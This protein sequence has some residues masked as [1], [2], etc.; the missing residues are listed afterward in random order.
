VTGAAPAPD[1]PD[2]VRLAASR[3]RL[4]L[5]ALGMSLSAAAFG[6]VYGLAARNAGFSVVE[7]LA[8]SVFVLAGAA[9]FAAVGLIVGG[10]PW[11]AIVLLTGLLNARHVLY[12]AALAPYLA[13]RSRLERAAMAHGLTDETFGI[14]FSH[15]RRLER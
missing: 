7:A 13:D 4:I 5:D 15:S 2:R 11:L 6:L 10:A 3:R 14:A 12:S 8:A 9:Q 1:D